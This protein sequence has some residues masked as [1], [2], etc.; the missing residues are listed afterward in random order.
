ME[1]DE[2]I[3]ATYEYLKQIFVAVMNN[4]KDLEDIKDLLKKIDE[5]LD[6]SKDS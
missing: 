1:K 4:S 6:K 2:I 5:K 3:K